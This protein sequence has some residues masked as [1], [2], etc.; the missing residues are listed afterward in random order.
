M[1]EPLAKSGETICRAKLQTLVPDLKRPSR[2]G[3]EVPKP[4]V[5]EIRG[6]N[7]ARAAPMLAFA[8]RSRCSA[9][10]MSGRRRRTSDGRPAAS[11]FGSVDGDEPLREEVGRD[12]RAGEEVERVARDR[13]GAGE[14]GDGRA[15]RL[16]LA[17]RLAELEVGADPR[18]AALADQVVRGLLRLE[19]RLRDPEVLLVGRE[20][21]A[22]CRRPRRRGRSARR[23]GP[24]RSRGTARGTGRSGSGCARRG[25]APTRPCRGRRCTSTRCSPARS[26]RCSPGSGT[27][28]PSPGRRSSG[29]A[30]SAG[31][32]RG[33]RPAR[34]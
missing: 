10:R 6:K 21:R 31:S 25:R 26:R 8:P 17:L 22:R 19:R 18:V 2:S 23:A 29:R 30:R 32:G 14:G 11:P 4:A 28:R 3:L 9:A 15:G 7:A 12:G 13:D 5:R 16:H 20:A 27:S 34:R 24:P 1:R 33:P